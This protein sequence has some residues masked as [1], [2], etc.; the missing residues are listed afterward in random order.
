MSVYLDNN[1][2]TPLKDSV[3]SAMANAL[4]VYGNPSS[5]HREGQ[6]ARMA[7][8]SARHQVADAVSV[9]SEQVVFTSSGTESNVM[10]LKGIIDTCPHKR[11]IT[12]PTEHSSVFSTAKA[13]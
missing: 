5:A 9:R 8:D 4:D 2:T 13:L 6:S 3:K 12:S 11:L 10:A 7:I 1:G